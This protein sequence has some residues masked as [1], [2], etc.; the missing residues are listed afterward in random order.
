MCSLLS[1][2]EHQNGQRGGKK[3][4]LHFAERFKPWNIHYRSVRFITQYWQ[5]KV[6]QYFGRE[7]HIWLISENIEPFR[8]KYLQGELVQARGVSTGS[9]PKMEDVRWEMWALPNCLA[10]LCSPRQR[11][12]AQSCWPVP[13][14]TCTYHIHR[15]HPHPRYLL[16]TGLVV[17]S[18]PQAGRQAL[19]T[20]N[21]VNILKVEKYTQTALTRP[22]NLWSF[23]CIEY[24]WSNLRDHGDLRLLVKI[25]I[26]DAI[27]KF[28]VP[29]SRCW[30]L[31]LL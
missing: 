11:Q 14:S 9:E 28:V 3:R 17:W 22:R 6:I 21:T 1:V 20:E 23:T 13:D 4:E 29:I 31:F 8:P 10:C 26:S 15:F 12:Q 7:G 27:L 24:E 2:V 5:Q 18:L 30:D 19:D 25:R 16:I